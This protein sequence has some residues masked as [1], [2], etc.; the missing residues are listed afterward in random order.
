MADTS[1]TAERLALVLTQAGM[2]RMAARVMCALL[3]T[4]QETTTAGELCEQLGASAGAVSGALKSLVSLDLAERVPAPGDRRDHYR[5]RPDG[6]AVMSSSQNRLLD[7]MVQAAEEGIQAAGEESVAGL[8]LREM[9]DFY[10]YMQ[11]ELPALID[12]WHEQR[13]MR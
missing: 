12:R 11:R 5:L 10:A 8:R 3:Y 6:W 13:G 2:Q 7:V 9:R 1:A 4:D